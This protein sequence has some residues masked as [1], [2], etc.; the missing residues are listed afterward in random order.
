MVEIT[1]PRLSPLDQGNSPFII[2]SYLKIILVLFVAGQALSLYTTDRF[3][4]KLLLIISGIGMAVAL[5]I[6]GISFSIMGEG[7]QA[8]YPW[9]EYLPIIGMLIYYLA[10]P[11]GFG[12]VIFVL[13]GEL[14]SPS[15]KGI[16]TS[17]STVVWF[18][19][20]ILL[21]SC[22]CSENY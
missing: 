12:S 22:Y 5:A 7:K 2:N 18:E 15:I 10:F 13:L 21:I 9:M 4:R 8:P 6:L 3:G 14:F 1:S 20:K 16:A 19:F 11:I 17:V